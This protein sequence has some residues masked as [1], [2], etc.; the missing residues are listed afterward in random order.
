MLIWFRTLTHIID[1][2]L[3]ET[4][5]KIQTC[6]YFNKNESDIPNEEEEEESNSNLQE[7]ENTTTA[8]TEPQFAEASIRND[9]NNI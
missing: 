4:L 9:V 2:A 3:K 6:S 1:K 7:E 8:E 5:S